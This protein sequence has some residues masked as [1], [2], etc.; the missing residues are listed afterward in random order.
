MGCEFEM[1]WQVFIISSQAAHSRETS[2]SHARGEKRQTRCVVRVI[3]SRATPQRVARAVQSAR[4]DEMRQEIRVGVGVRHLRD[5]ALG[6][7][8]GCGGPFVGWAFESA[9]RRRAGKRGERGR[10]EQRVDRHGRRA[11]RRTR[12]VTRDGVVGSRR[13]G[14]TARVPD[15]T[16]ASPD[17][18]LFGL[19]NAATPPP[20]DRKDP[21]RENA[22]SDARTRA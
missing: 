1:S 3:V 5:S 21:P 10:G 8:G 16:R 13:D 4:D 17:G 2:S 11:R 22:P 6:G 15:R 9:S 7:R 20:R 14:E 19:D 12:V 18:C